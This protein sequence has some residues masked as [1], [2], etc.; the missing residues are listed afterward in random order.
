MYYTL[1]QFFYIKVICD[2]IR[3]NQY[4]VNVLV[5][6][7]V[8]PGH[9]VARQGPLVIA[10]YSSNKHVSELAVF[11]YLGEHGAHNCTLYWETEV[12]GEC[13]TTLASVVG[14]VVGMWPT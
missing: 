14:L 13:V 10:R 4:I 2:N 8:R 5:L 11:W 7:L 3:K 9:Y 12:W 6:R 1:N